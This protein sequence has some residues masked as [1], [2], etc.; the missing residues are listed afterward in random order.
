[1][2]AITLDN[3]S[4]RFGDQTVIASADLDIRHGEFIV[5]VGPSG[6]GK[7][8]M[9]RMIAGLESIDQGE[10]RIDGRRANELNP[11]QRGIAMV[12]QSYALY[13]HMTVHRNLSFA[14]EIAKAP[15]TEIA[16]RVGAIAQMLQLENLLDRL[17]KHLS[18]GQRQRV[19]I[20]RAIIRNPSI[21]LFDEPLSN[22]DA[23]LRGQM[24]I[25]IARLHKAIGA[26][27]IYVTHDQA[28]A[29]TLADRIVVFNEGRIQ[30]QG[31]PMDLY[32]RPANRFVASFL[33]AHPMNFLRARHDDAG[34]R[35]GSDPIILPAAR[36]LPH[37]DLVLGVRP[38]HLHIG[39]AGESGIRAK[40]QAVE[41]LGDLSLIH[42]QTEDGTMLCIRSGASEGIAV[43]DDIAC[44]TDPATI[45]FFSAD[46]RGLS[47]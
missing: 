24:R 12:F 25:E 44:Q 20:G 16:E 38:E 4:K 18:G 19:A 27:F 39:Q 42:A 11:Q 45:H 26:T 10:L 9:L 6:C 37:G 41:L 15:K 8:T 5:F 33:G 32:S 31:T 34:L 35:V 7:S 47:L 43:G 21:C 28:E 29:M 46:E 40:V 17:P 3:L 2:A 13:P 14:L 30:Q 23:N 22:L 36:T 1:M